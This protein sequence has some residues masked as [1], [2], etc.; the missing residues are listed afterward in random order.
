MSVVEELFA[1]FYGLTHYEKQTA[2]VQ[3][4]VSAKPAGTGT[5]AARRKRKTLLLCV[6]RHGSHTVVNNNVV[7]NGCKSASL[8]IFGIS[9]KYIRKM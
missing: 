8:S 6:A 5:G 9:D 4:L 1:D 3:S 7:H 2:Y